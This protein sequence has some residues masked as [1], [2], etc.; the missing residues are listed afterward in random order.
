MTSISYPTYPWIRFSLSDVSDLFVAP[1]Y[2]WLP[3][4]RLATRMWADSLD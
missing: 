3:D 1:I 4:P 2:L